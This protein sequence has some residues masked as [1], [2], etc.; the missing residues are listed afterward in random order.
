MV[1]QGLMAFSGSFEPSKDAARPVV[2]KASIACWA[3]W[4]SGR[5]TEPMAAKMAS[6]SHGNPSR[7]LLA[8]GL[9]VYRKETGKLLCTKNN[10]NDN[11]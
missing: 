7:I 9:T 10:C 3:G 4:T 6:T 11:L 1:E 2:G 8:H 5:E